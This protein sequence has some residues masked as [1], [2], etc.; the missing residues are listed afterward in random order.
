MEKC[1]TP[2]VPY[3]FLHTKPP[4]KLTVAVL[5]WVFKGFVGT[6][7]VGTPLTLIPLGAVMVWDPIETIWKDGKGGRWESD[8]GGR[9]AVVRARE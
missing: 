3:I 5:G 6:P 2:R 8:G 7:F 1:L 9:H 4:N